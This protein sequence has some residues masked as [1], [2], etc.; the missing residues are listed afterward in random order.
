MTPARPPQR[1]SNAVPMRLGKYCAGVKKKF[2]KGP[3]GR[4]LRI[5]PLVCSTF[6][7]VIIWCV[8]T[9]KI[10]WKGFEIQ[11]RHITFTSST[12]STRFSNGVLPEN[13]PISPSSKS[14]CFSFTLVQPDPN[15]YNILCAG[16]SR[17]LA[18][19]RSIHRTSLC[20]GLTGGNGSFCG[21]RGKHRPAISI[22]GFIF[23]GPA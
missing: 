20:P 15:S 6:T 12:H 16:S 5:T 17:N 21:F 11:K 13:H 8:Q 9:S 2:G 14:T 22:A 4:I 23:L 19:T 18:L 10:R 3:E 1:P 7:Y